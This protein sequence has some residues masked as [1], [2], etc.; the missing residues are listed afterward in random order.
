MTSPD[1]RR[2]KDV[3]PLRECCNRA[4]G[5]IED[6]RPAVRDEQASAIIRPQKLLEA[7]SGTTPEHAA[8]IDV[9]QDELVPRVVVGE[10][11]R[12]R[13]PGQRY[14]SRASCTWR[15][16]TVTRSVAVDDAQRRS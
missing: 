2:R 1:E 7:C 13:A 9:Q 8:P 4:S 14:Q 3:P 11:V 10:L 16:E 6:A 5:R 15:N 12:A